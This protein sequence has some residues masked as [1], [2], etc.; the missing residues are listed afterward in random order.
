[1]KLGI[2]WVITLVLLGGCTNEGYVLHRSG[3]SPSNY[4]AKFDALDNA[5]LNELS[6]KEFVKFVEAMSPETGRVTC[7]PAP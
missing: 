7:S 3:N 4:I 6:C 5:S 2:L 1:M